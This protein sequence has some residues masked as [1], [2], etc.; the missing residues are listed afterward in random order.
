MKHIFNLTNKYIVLLTPLLLY[1]LL[2]SVY[3]AVS[4]MGGNAGLII[5]SLALFFLMTGAFSAGWFYMVKL[6]VIDQNEDS[7]SLIKEF[8]TG[9]GEYILP[10]SGMLAIVLLFSLIIL[11][12]TY[13]LGLLLIGDIGVSLEAL[14]KAM[15]STETIK[16]FIAGLSIEELVKISHWNL[17]LLG[18]VTI[19]YFLLI[20]YLPALFFESKNPIKAF[21]LSFKRLFSKKFINTVGIYLLIFIA[22]FILSFLSAFLANNTIMHFIL[23]LVNFYFITFVSILI[24]NFYY[25]NF[26]QNKLGQN[27]DVEI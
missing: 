12:I 4:L 20:F 5:F 14:S 16:T 15:E 24:F 3:M 23:T 27:I 6:A 21:G 17:L 10:A 25:E 22:N 11:F 9:V 7:N 13:K 19:T 2:S 26:V 8:L 1:S 18:S